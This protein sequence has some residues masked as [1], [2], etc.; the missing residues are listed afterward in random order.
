[1]K[2]E[3]K[4]KR[5]TEIIETQTDI[6][7]VDSISRVR[8]ILVNNF[9]NIAKKFPGQTLDEISEMK[10]AFDMIGIFDKC[11]ENAGFIL[12]EDTGFYKIK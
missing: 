10:E 11:C 7:G 6:I 8:T 12:D 3:D 5:D 4:E 9:C 1:M 2:S